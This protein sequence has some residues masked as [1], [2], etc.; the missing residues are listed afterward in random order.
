M[1]EWVFGAVLA[2]A[3]LVLWGFMFLLWKGN[4]EGGMLIRPRVSWKEF[5]KLGRLADGVPGP[6]DYHT[7]GW[8]DVLAL[9]LINFAVGVTVYQQGADWQAVLVSGL[10]G[11][12]ASYGFFRMATKPKRAA[13]DIDWWFRFADKQVHVSLA[14]WIHL[15]YFAFQAGITAL[16]V[17]YLVTSRMTVPITVVGLAGAF[18]YFTAFV[19]DKAEGHFD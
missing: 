5:K 8:G 3:G 11:F 7:N 10:L 12:L 9:P 16:G 4:V 19:A 6:W 13:Q 14:G 2:L 18:L 15:V 1:N 17:G